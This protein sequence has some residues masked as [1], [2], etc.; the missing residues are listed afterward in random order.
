[1][2]VKYI[3]ILFSQTLYETEINRQLIDLNKK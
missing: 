3:D 1:M 2:K